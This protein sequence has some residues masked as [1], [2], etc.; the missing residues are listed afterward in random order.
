MRKALSTQSRFDCQ[1]VVNVELNLNCRDE[2]RRLQCSP[3]LIAAKSLSPL[4]GWCRAIVA[5]HKP[6]SDVMYSSF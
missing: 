5:N 3:Q 2:E 6:Q 1:P 4:R